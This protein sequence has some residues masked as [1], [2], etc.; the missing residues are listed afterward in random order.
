[1]QLGLGVHALHLQF[2]CSVGIHSA[3]NTTQQAC[4]SQVFPLKLCVVLDAWDPSTQNTQT[5][6][7]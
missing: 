3:G 2:W 5:G 1:M 7:S 6:E 4:L